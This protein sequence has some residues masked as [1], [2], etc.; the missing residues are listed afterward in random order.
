MGWPF[1]FQDIGSAT[2]V[3]PITTASVAATTAP[4]AATTAP[5]AAATAPVAAA[6]VVTSS[7]VPG[8]ASAGIV[9]GTDDGITTLIGHSRSGIL[10]IGVRRVDV[11]VP[12]GELVV[13]PITGDCP[14]DSSHETREEPA[15]AT[16]T[17]TAAATVV[18]GARPHS[19][20]LHSHS[21][22]LPRIARIAS[23]GSAVRPG[24]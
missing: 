5:V 16:T 22:H 13:Q 9:V 6:G 14:T 17:I 23:N 4:V 10:R 21:S 2:G 12:A 18:A 1:A 11:S 7:I 15:P 8:S 20:T 24:P 19:R 3:L